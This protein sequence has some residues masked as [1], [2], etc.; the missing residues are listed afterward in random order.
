[1][2]SRDGAQ[3]ARPKGASGLVARLRSS[4]LADLVLPRECGGCL[5]PGS[6]WCL[7]CERALGQLAFVAPALGAPAFGASAFG[8]SALGLASRAGSGCSARAEPAGAGGGGPWVVPHP[9]PTDMPPVYAWGVY[10]DPLRA[11]VSA[12]KDA[13]RR[14]L[15]AVLVPLLAEALHGALTG[16][17]WHEGVAVVVPAPSSRRSVRQRGD[18]PM[19]RLCEAAVAA[20]P[21]G[22]GPVLRVAPALRHVR[23]VE[24]QS[25]LGTAERRGNLGGALDVDPLWSNVIRGRRCLLVDDVVT[26]GATLAEA[27]RA[28]WAAGAH[29]IVG[30][31]MAATQRTR[32]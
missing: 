26:T 20:L 28:L 11:V 19:V 6:D 2:G 15:L 32:G 13:G 4:E 16:S 25:G 23:R 29:E 14:D 10:A 17:G 7:R 22:P 31:S 8:A 18:T 9:A 24:D 5:R 1:M 21:A 3:A 30:A 12:W 27:S